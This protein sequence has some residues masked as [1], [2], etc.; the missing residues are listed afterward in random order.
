MKANHEDGYPSQNYNVRKILFAENLYETKRCLS[1]NIN[2]C[3]R[4]I[5]LQRQPEECN[6]QDRWGV[7]FSL[8]N[9]HNNTFISTTEFTKLTK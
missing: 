2:S 9:K 3:H 8:G 1:M 5:V 7:I 4:S 6:S